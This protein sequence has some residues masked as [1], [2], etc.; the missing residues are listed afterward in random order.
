LRSQVR[1]AAI[2]KHA[3]I[4]EKAARDGAETVRRI[5]ELGRSERA[6]DF[7]PVD[8]RA[9]LDDVIEL[10]RA[11]T[12]NKSVAI[13]ADGSDDIRV[14][15]NPSELREVLINLVHNAVDALPNAGGSIQLSVRVDEDV[16]DVDGELPRPVRILVRDNGQGIPDD[17]IGRIFDPYFTTKGERGTGLGLSVSHSIVRRHGGA[18]HAASRTSGAERGTTFTLELPRF[19]DDSVLVS[20]AAATATAG[21]PGRATVLVVDDEENIREILSEM[22]MTADHDVITAADGAEALHKLQNTPAVDL[23]FTDLG[24]PGMSGYEVAQEM[25]RLRPDLLVGLVTGWGATLDLEKAR[26]HGVDLVISKPF[27]FEQVLGI[28]D[29]ALLARAKR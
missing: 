10:T 24:L 21:A 8:V 25:K 26:A 28:V 18:M 5:Q 20:A 22:L 27:R 7:V 6:D 4:I 16:G 14:P 3:D 2:L 19:L 17:V 12:A 1:D 13:D 29:E 9:I 15:G 23:V 11:R